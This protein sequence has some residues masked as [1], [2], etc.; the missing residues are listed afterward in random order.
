MASNDVVNDDRIDA[1]LRGLLDDSGAPHGWAAGQRARLL[2]RID[3][4]SDRERSDDATPPTDVIELSRG[5]ISR[6][7]WRFVGATA[8]AALVIGG[9]AVVLHRDPNPGMGASASETST[10]QEGAVAP[11]GE[12][13][14]W[15]QLLPALAPADGEQL[16]VDVGRLYPSDPPETTSIVARVDGT[17]ASDVMVVTAVDRERFEATAAGV[18]GTPTSERIGGTDVS[19]Y[20]Y[21]GVEQ[22]GTV[23]VPG[24]DGLAVMVKGADP[25]AFVEQAGVTFASATRDGLRSADVGPMLSISRLPSGYETLVEPEALPSG[26]RRLPSIGIVGSDG[27]ARRIVNVVPGSLAWTTMA[28]AADT[29]VTALDDGRWWITTT[30]GDSQLIWRVGDWDW[31][32]VIFQKEAT[33]SAA[34]LDQLQAVADRVELVDFD[35]WQT[36]YPAAVAQAEAPAATTTVPVTT[37]ASS[38]SDA[39]GWFRDVAG[40]LPES[41]RTIAIAGL[42]QTNVRLTAIDVTTGTALEMRVS[43]V[44]IEADPSGSDLPHSFDSHG[45]WFELNDGANLV[46]VDGRQ[47]QVSCVTLTAP[48]TRCSEIPGYSLDPEQ[49][50][51]ITANLAE[52]LTPARLAGWPSPT[53]IAVTVEQVDAAVAVLDPGLGRTYTIPLENGFTVAYAFNGVTEALRVS[54]TTGYIGVDAD[55]L[56]TNSDVTVRLRAETLVVVTRPQGSELLGADRIVDDLLPAGS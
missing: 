46:T 54:I 36:R 21:S 9:I 22:W 28:G 55:R 37:T 53:P 1:M 31:A 15:P 25:V 19:I 10:T 38:G 11:S 17:S 12:M 26:G 24:I 13:S 56:T 3:G 30:Q 14:L 51:D 52:A 50:R 6:R 39:P 33:G 8:A 23:L 32:E 44:P 20:T 7:P 49:L 5:E 45:E 43:K 48:E 40:L 4:H 35:T 18:Y 47:A 27:F 2:D 29:T 41:Y 34:T 42:D 16:E